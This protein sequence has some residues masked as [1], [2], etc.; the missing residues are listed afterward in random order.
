MKESTKRVITLPQEAVDTS[1]P[2]ALHGIW[3]MLTKD[4][5]TG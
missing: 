5:D 2:F 3:P 4:L 1:P